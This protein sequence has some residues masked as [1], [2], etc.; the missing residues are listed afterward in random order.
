MLG[1]RAVQLH[2][3]VERRLHQPDPAARR[4]HLLVPELVRRAR[5]Q[6]E[7]AVHA[8]VDQARRPSDEDPFGVEG[9]AHPLGERRPRALARLGD[10]GDPRPRAARAG[11]PASRTARRAAAPQLRARRSPPRRP[12]S[13]AL[14]RARP[15]PGLDRGRAALEAAA[16]TGPAAGSRR[17]SARAASACSSCQSA[18]GSSVSATTVASAAGRGWSRSAT[19]AIR[20]RRPREPEKSL[21]RS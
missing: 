16:R 13:G 19:R 9:R 11:T 8:V 7:A 2:R 10:V 18:R 1:D 12:S 21:P 3:P 14:A 5:R 4:V 17:R 20:P 6:A 15:R